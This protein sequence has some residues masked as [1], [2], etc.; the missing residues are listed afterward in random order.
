MSSDQISK[1]TEAIASRGYLPD[2]DGLKQNVERRRQI[3]KVWHV[4]LFMATIFG[5][6]VLAT[7]LYTIIDEAIGVVALQSAIP[8]AELVQPYDVASLE[9]LSQEQL[10]EILEGESSGALR[11]LEREMPFAERGESELQQIIRDQVLN[12]EVVGSWPLTQGILNYSA[13]EAEVAEEFPRAELRWRSWISWDFISTPMNSNPALAGIRTALLGTIWVILI[14]LFVSF[15]LGVGAAIYLEEYAADTRSDALRRINGF[16]QTNI[17][18]LAGV[19]SIIYG[20]LGLAI[21]VRAL[22]PV[23]SGTAFGAARD[24][25]TA[26]GRTIMPPVSHW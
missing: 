11:R 8:E 4:L 7:L 12:E 18:N 23:T 15:P 1:S 22:E 10:V 25:T 17:N 13:I 16:I 5:V 6:F 9:D 24:V 20:M 21:F 26:N 3:G 2:G 14:T 19:P